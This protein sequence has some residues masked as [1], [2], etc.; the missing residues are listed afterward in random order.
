M[1]YLPITI[2]GLIVVCIIFGVPRTITVYG[3]LTPEHELTYVNQAPVVSDMVY[4]IIECESSWRP[5]VYGDG[6]KAHGYA[7]FHKPTFEW[8]K[9]LS[10]KTDLDYYEPSDQIEL[11]T[12]ALEN[13]R[14]YLWTCYR[15]L[16]ENK[17]I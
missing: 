14:G 5:D 12:W 1:K 9:E 6:G 3:L 4:K 8:L 16:Y 13:G 11:L 10:G 7:Q 2:I 17:K 15:T